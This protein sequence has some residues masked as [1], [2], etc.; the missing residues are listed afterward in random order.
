MEERNYTVYIHIS[1]NNKYYVGITKQQV[2]RRWRGGSGYKRNKNFYSAIQK[3]GWN[4]F[5]HEIIASHLTKDEACKFEITL[6]SA[7]KSNQK[8]FGYNKSI[9]GEGSLGVSPT[10]EQRNKKREKLIGRKRPKEVCEQISLSKIG[11]KVSIETK[12]KISNALIGHKAS[13]QTKKK[14]SEAGK[15]RSRSGRHDIKCVCRPILQ[16]DK[17]GKFIRKW[18]SILEATNG[19]NFKSHGSMDNVLSVR[20]KTAHG[21]IFEYA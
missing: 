18:D 7:L 17:N 10:E 4:A 20:S 3:Y 12:Q 1:P 21:F 9:G 15:M 5:Q 11:H 14:Q 19:L 13:E 16:Y 6:I 8:D 2:K